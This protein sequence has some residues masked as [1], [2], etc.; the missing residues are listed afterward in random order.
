MNKASIGTDILPDLLKLE[1]SPWIEREKLLSESDIE[2]FRQNGYSIVSGLVSNHEIDEIIADA[3][4]LARGGYPCEKLTPV[5]PEL[6]DDQA[7]RRILCIHQPHFISSVIQKYV[8]HP[9][10]C[11][12]L[13]QLTGCMLPWW[14]GSVKCM[15]S[16]LFIKPPTFQGQ[17]WHQD[18]VYIPD[19]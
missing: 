12:V 3:I 2:S 7:L 16:M 13:S 1:S 8:A 14:D 11:G 18:E 17:A 19:S 4:K 5:A 15:Q 6:T 9:G 10:V